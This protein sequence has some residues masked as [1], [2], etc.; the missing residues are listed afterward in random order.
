MKK[1][2]CKLSV[3]EWVCGLFK[4]CKSMSTHT[5]VQRDSRLSLYRT[6]FTWIWPLQE[7]TAIENHLK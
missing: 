5:N 2:N 4:R 3:S 7:E 1:E 6:L